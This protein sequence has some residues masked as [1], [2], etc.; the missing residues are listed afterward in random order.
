MNVVDK[1]IFVKLSNYVGSKLSLD[2]DIIGGYEIFGLRIVDIE[3]YGG[4][5]CFDV[6]NNVVLVGWINLMIV[7]IVNW[8]V[9]VDVFLV[10][11]FVKKYDVL[12]LL[13]DVD[14]LI[15]KI[16]SEIVK[17]NFDNIFII[18]GIISVFKNVENILKKYGF[19]DWIGG[20]ICY[21][22]LKNIVDWMGNYSQVVVV[23]G[24]V[25]IDVLLIVLYVVMNGYLILFVGDNNI[26]SD[27]KILSNVIIVGGLLSVSIG[28][29][30]ILKK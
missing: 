25:F 12:I 15:L 17:L 3:W 13:I 26:C 29:E 22:V 9:F 20:V 18:G 7:V 23:M 16:E 6:V 4:V 28:V 19:I 11:L 27:Y 21:E 14:L 8:D 2:V 24:M 10:I 1:I 5:I 30:V